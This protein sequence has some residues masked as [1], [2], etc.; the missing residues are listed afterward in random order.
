MFKGLAIFLLVLYILLWIPWVQTQIGNIFAYAMSKA[1]DTTVTIDRVEITPLSNFKFHNFFIQDHDNDTLIFA[2]YAEAQSYN[3]F[4]MFKK[5]VDI[6]HIIVNDAVFKV[7]R[8]PE[9]EFFNIHFLIAFFEAAPNSKGPRPKKFELYFGGASLRNARVHLADTAIGTTAIIT[10]DTGYVHRHDVEGVDMIGKKVWANKAHLDG[11]DVTVYIHDKV[12]IPNIDSSFWEVPVD[13]TIP[14]WNVG[15]EK[16]M[17][18]NAHFRLIN[19]RPDMLPDSTRVLDFSNLDIADISLDVDSFR[20][21]KEV[22]TG[23]VN[24]LHGLDHGGI[25]LKSFR[26]NTL[27]SPTKLAFEN[28]RLE[29]NNSTLGHALIFKYKRYGDFYKFPDNVKI[30]GTFDSTT[31]ITFRDIAAFAP[32]IQENV[33]IKSNLDKDILVQGKFRGTINNFR[34]R[35]VDIKVG[36]H[37][38]IMGNLSMNDI[39]YPDAAFMDLNLKKV[40]TNYKDLKAILP[41]VK[42]PPNLETLGTIRFRGS[43]TGFFQDFV[44][45]G[46]LD[47]QLGRIKSDLQL[48][49]RKGK[50]EAAYKGGLQFKRFDVGTFL[51]NNDI[52]QITIS[53]KVKGKGLTLETLDAELQNAKIDS[54]DFKQY[55]YKDIQID[56]LFKQKKFDG[57]IISRDSNMYVFVRGMV[58]LNGELPKI[59]ILG[60]VPNI[61]FKNVNISP[62][63]IGLHL[64]TFDINIEGSNLDNFTGTMS[65]RGIKG[66]RGDIHSELKRI[67]VE[68]KD[69][70]PVDSNSNSTRVIHLNSDIIDVNVYG[71]YDIVN[72]VKSIDNF[73]RVNHPNLYREIYKNQLPIPDD[74][75][76]PLD[77]FILTTD[78]ASLAVIPQ[79]EFGM[80]ISI[81]KTTKNITQLIDK[82]FKSLEEVFISGEYDGK[83]GMLR[84]DGNIGGISIGDISIQDVKIDTGQAL[85]RS[86][87]LKTNV[88]AFLIKDSTFIPNIGIQ[89]N[90]VGDSVHFSAKADAVG[91]F[92]SDIDVRGKL[93]VKEKL[94]VLKLDTSNLKILNQPWTI[95]DNNHIKI[96]DKTLDIKDV[97]LSSDQKEIRLSSINNNKGAR[98]EAENMNLG[99][100]Y[101][102]MKPLPKIEIDGIFSGEAQ[103]ANIFTQKDV[104]AEVR[105]D[106]LIINDDYWG[107]NS[108]LVVN[109]DSIKST[110][111]GLFTHSSDF[112]DS[113]YVTANFT[114]SI[115]T[116]EPYLQNLLD[117]VVTAD[118]AKAKI[119]EYFLKEQISNT[120]GYVDASARIYGNIKGPQTVMNIEGDGQMFDA[121]T[122]VN[123]LQT[124]Y[125]L[126]DGKIKM[127]N[128]GFHIDPVLELAKDNKRESGGVGVVEI[129]EPDKKGYI[130]G[131]LTHDHLKNFGLDI[132]AT[133]DNNLAMN[134]TLEDNG[135]FYGTVYASGLVSFKGPF[136]KLKLKVEATTEDNTV[137]NLPTGGPLEVA[138]TNY[139][140]FFDSHAKEDSSAIKSIKD[141]LLAGLDIE[142]IANIKPSALAR[143][144]IDE[145]A[146]DIIEGRGQSNDMRV[147]YSPTGELQIFGNYEITEGNYLLTYRNIIN[148][149]FTVIPGGTITW[150]EN[151]GDPYK[152]QL[153]I[154]ASYEKGLGVS[155]LIKSY[156]IDDAEKAKLANV[157]TKVNLLLDIQGELFSPEINYDIKI[158]DVDSRLQSDVSL[159]LRRIRS[160]KDELNRQ[161][162]GIL[163]LQQFLPL[164]N[165]Q[166]VNVIA[167]G[168]NTGIST[169]SELISQQLSL[170]INDL[171]AG[172]IKDVD[173]ISSLEFDFNFNVRDSE[174]QSANSRTSNVRVGS[175]FKFLDDRLSIYAG[176]N[177]DIPSEANALS[178]TNDGNYIGGDFIVEYSISESGQ[179]KVK[180]YN[181]TESTFLGN[182]T[183][184]GIG[185]SYRKQFD[186]LQ[187]LIDEARK[188]R[189]RNQKERYTKQVERF[190][191]KLKT[192]EKTLPATTKD[193]K[194]RQL[195]KQQKR[196]QQ[197]LEIAKKELDKLEE[198][199]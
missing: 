163:A 132:F 45:Y 38:H 178:N 71:D 190:E 102:L 103:I 18:S 66:H 44:A 138:E 69:I 194:K 176:A 106:T 181:K 133:L 68:A 82:N 161:V 144:I 55:R 145:K 128:T 157:P 185:V 149:P 130:G 17:L 84:I 40:S 183:R 9:A 27:I 81:P 36:S 153:D 5:K 11:F 92:A 98:V 101:S 39:V 29:T 125:A 2:K 188:N 16:L 127:D 19:Q 121:Q 139:I 22:F 171:I 46:E 120:Q 187:D 118:G 164:E 62:E 123:F 186:T 117:I 80:V 25:E 32:P 20:L 89:L 15:C 42:L 148:K 142:I 58:D 26:A 191:G 33:F 175:N 51:G 65:I 90:A 179:L 63:N 195:L 95:N 75:T 72:L 96:G 156:I 8:R 108:K 83:G 129:S 126:D 30:L 94:V 13:S 87:Q 137:F 91:G 158:T 184:T 197:K 43:Y 146:G 21:Q 193:S 162:F 53:S 61:N 76:I 147:L 168:I 50:T 88:N 54:F 109:A 177:L 60:N 23:Q 143:I 113:L 173:F 111:Q 28:F 167:S 3:V 114:P 110:F 151:N 166:N 160:D 135:T 1:W 99:W 198:E 155:N 152:A 134:T 189:K 100:L 34:A 85:G 47:T 180:A 24:Q 64:D 70:P 7:Q 199:K 154:Q 169:V 141:Q 79:Q 131:S 170:Y 67:G 182:N 12:E 57:D 172:V 107:S 116:E 93:E 192:I 174:T 97:V 37:S 165:G 59:D 122:T 112:V 77:T 49:L 52:G 124:T 41:F 159:A 10:C 31:S 78:T 136:E 74:T 115:A 119:L 6:G 56:G 35:N 48:N 86:F 73:I 150:G 196:F 140:T 4:S 105:L 14:Y 104:D